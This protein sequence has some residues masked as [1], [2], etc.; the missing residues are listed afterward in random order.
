MAFD[1]QAQFLELSAPSA[2]TSFNPQTSFETQKSGIFDPQSQF[3]SL[4]ISA[5][6]KEKNIFVTP[7]NVGDLI[8]DAV[9]FT[10]ISKDLQKKIAPKNIFNDSALLIGKAVGWCGDYATMMSTATRVG[11]SWAEKKTH[12]DKRSGISPGDKI[13]LPYGVDKKG[14]GYGHVQVALT[15]EDSL[16]N[17]LIAQSNADGRQNRGE[18]PGVVTYG[19]I[20]VNDLNKRYGQNWGAASGR[21]KVNPLLNAPPAKAQPTQNITPTQPAQKPDNGNWVTNLLGLTQ[22]K[23]LTNDQAPPI[24]LNIKD[25]KVLA[26]YVIQNNI[27][28][29]QS[30]KWWVES[31]VKG[32]AWDLI[33]KRQGAGDTGKRFTVD[34][35]QKLQTETKSGNE[36]LATLLNVLDPNSY[37][38]IH[39]SQSDSAKASRA[40]VVQNLGKLTDQ[41][42]LSPA[43]EVGRGVVSGL[44]AFGKYGESLA[45]DL[46]G[47]NINPLA[48]PGLIQNQI[49]SGHGN[50]DQLAT[51][52]TEVANAATG[53]A[54]LVPNIAF[55]LV[56][57]EAD[58][59]PAAAYLPT[60]EK[61][62]A[63]FALPANAVSAV[64]TGI[65][66]LA[67]QDVNSQEFQVR[68]IQPLQALTNA[69]IVLGGHAVVKHGIEL[70]DFLTTK[71]IKVPQGDVLKAFREIT[72]GQDAGA[73]PEV[74]KAVKDILN[75]GREAVQQKEFL[76]RARTEGITITQARSFVKWWNDWM[77]GIKP[78][79]VPRQIAGLLTD[80][81]K[82][83]TGEI[84]PVEFVDRAA[85]TLV[86]GE[87]AGLRT[88]FQEQAKLPAPIIPSTELALAR[89]RMA[90][91][92]EQGKKSILDVQANGQPALSIETFVYSD[93]KVGIGYTIETELGKQIVPIQGVFDTPREAVKAIVPEIEKLIAKG[94]DIASEAIRSALDTLKEGD[95][96]SVPKEVEL[97]PE[98]L[99]DLSTLSRAEIQKRIDNIIT[100]YIQNVL[101]PS[102]KEAPGV[103]QPKMK[104]QKVEIKK[105]KESTTTAATTLR[106]TAVRQLTAG[107][108][109]PGI[110]RLP[111]NREFLALRE[112][113]QAAPKETPAIIS[114][115]ESRQL[116]SKTYVAE[117]TG[118][119]KVS[120]SKYQTREVN[121]EYKAIKKADTLARARKFVTDN[122]KFALEVARG[123]ENAPEGLNTSAVNQVVMQDALKGGDIALYEEILRSDIR[124]AGASAQNL[125][126]RTELYNPERVEY[127]MTRAMDSIEKSLNIKKLVSIAEYKK[128]V[129]VDDVVKK[130]AK[131]AKKK[132][133]KL[134]DAEAAQKLLESLFCK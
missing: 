106:E 80:G 114:T 131:K 69:A 67:G 130:E 24:P 92:I 29:L 2:P 111:P 72:T 88:A 117:G 75:A 30:K 12:I 46:L 22:K 19:I 70:R 56:P 40:N 58:L 38:P 124:Q 81:K 44:E 49:F 21:L 3:E 52:V 48:L 6:K 28:D 4:N 1:P 100:E 126:I 42:V 36:V 34:Q 43:K 65:G 94:S 91:L 68:V 134:E 13:L 5:P 110:G 35:G 51:G 98:A 84:S 8:Y 127:W 64:A 31:A 33:Q 121:V 37:L 118:E 87:S 47:Q 89:N 129:T 90:E 77:N 15:P 133:E 116:A 50:V 32:Q 101:K 45:D 83:L 73:R 123:I 103:K 10:A 9:T 95:F 132:L 125:A 85:K 55:S 14:N 74:V 97:T 109:E 16:G 27:T 105:V 41:L 86:P 63:V 71:K 108:N 54:V 7:T 11:N 104:G 107:V 78:K 76:R 39:A 60:K 57:S 79:D 112:A 120:Q 25:P 82:A 96:K 119:T 93:G 17:V 62:D 128:G 99:T 18:G 102:L 23:V 66:M 122:P 59:G 113:Y 53:A 26:D 61:I 115:P 20:N